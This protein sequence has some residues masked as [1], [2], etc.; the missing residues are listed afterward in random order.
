MDLLMTNLPS[1]E[2]EKMVQTALK[3]TTLGEN[4][5]W[6]TPESFMMMLTSIPQYT[7]RI[8]VWAYLN[9]FE[10]AFQRISEAEVAISSAIDYLRRSERVEKLLALILHVGNYL[11]GGTVR[12]RADGFDLETLTKLG[13]LKASQD[14]TLLDFIVREM[15]KDC[16][17]E[18]QEMYQPAAEFQSIKNAK[19]H[20][21]TEMRDELNALLKQADGYV[22]Q[23]EKA[24]DSNFSKDQGPGDAAFAERAQKL[25]SC[26]DRLRS[27]SAA[28]DKLNSTYID[29]CVWFN[30]DTQ[31]PRPFDDFLGVWDGFLTDTKQAVE[32]AQKKREKEK[33]QSLQ[34]LKPERTTS[35]PPQRSRDRSSS[36]NS[37]V[38]DTAAMKKRMSRT[39]EP[40][41]RSLMQRKSMPPR[42]E[43][44]MASPNARRR[45]DWAVA[46]H[47]GAAADAASNSSARTASKN[48][49]AEVA[50][51]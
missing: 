41:S 8:N 12:G 10:A 37:V 38:S 28:F 16:P 32:A 26:I 33:R 27:T 11:N 6:D 3:E 50:Q 21:I 47:E 48:E 9:S 51:T 7:L 14:G 43:V 30:M 18:L 1:A 4:E 22:Q 39:P 46:G 24:L 36:V 23:V 15:D 40:S 49:N 2:E 13:K 34:P 31:K 42:V 29:L 45:I 20:K 44:G 35:L 5:V 19:K 25:K 17:G